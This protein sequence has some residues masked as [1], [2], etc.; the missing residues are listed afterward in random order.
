M[1]VIHKGQQYYDESLYGRKNGRF[2][3]STDND[4]I[5]TYDE[6][7]NRLSGASRNKFMGNEAIGGVNIVP[8]ELPF[9]KDMNNVEWFRNFKFKK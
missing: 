9:I 2:T 8:N 4:N 3:T 1:G 6:Y 7:R 5:V